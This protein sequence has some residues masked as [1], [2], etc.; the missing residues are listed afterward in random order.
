MKL[1]AERVRSLLDEMDEAG[2][3]ELLR[4]VF[5]ELS[6]RELGIAADELIKE[7]RRRGS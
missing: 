3:V 6:P 5:G 1:T 2:I 7:K 4:I